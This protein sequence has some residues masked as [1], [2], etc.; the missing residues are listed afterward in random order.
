MEENR[1]YL[2]IPEKCE[3]LHAPSNL[4]ALSIWNERNRRNL[5]YDWSSTLWI[6]L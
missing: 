1:V 4:G 6:K 2:Y 5:Q 3:M